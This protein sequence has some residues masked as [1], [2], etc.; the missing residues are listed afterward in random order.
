[1]TT[2]EFVSLEKNLLTELPGFAIKGPLM[3]IPPAKRLLRGISFEG[4]SFDK[5]S[6]YVAMFVMPLCVPTSYLYFNFG[7]RV[8]RKEGADRWNM[9]GMPNVVTELGSA[10]KLQAMPF[11][12]RVESLLDFVDEARSSSG[13]H[14]PRAIAFALARAGQISQAVGVLDQLF[15]QLDLNVAWQR[16]IGDQSKALRAK[17][18]TSPIEAQQQL[19]AWEIESVRNLGLEGFR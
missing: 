14:T 4:S 8:R 9:G 3:F 15:S 11:L 1:M 2:K 17:L 12:S 5:T 7:N 19:E 18:V 10:L 13:N 16:K 6:F